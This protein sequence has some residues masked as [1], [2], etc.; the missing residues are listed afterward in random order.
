MT[1]TIELLD[2]NRIAAVTLTA[3]TDPG[4]TLREVVAAGRVNFRHR[5]AYLIDCRAVSSMCD[6]EHFYEFEDPDHWVSG[7]VQ[8]A[9]VVAEARL[10]EPE[11]RVS[12]ETA[13]IC[14]LPRR[15]FITMETA[16][17]WL[18]AKR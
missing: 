1:W 4:G 10:A 7:P 17:A 12:Q 11:W 16:L 13:R 14:G 18:R 8:I 3:D 9:A 15:A 2:D 5:L 6:A